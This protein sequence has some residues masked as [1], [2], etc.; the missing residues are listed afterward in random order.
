[1]P[2]WKADDARPAT[3]GMPLQIGSLYQATLGQKQYV[4]MIA[5]SHNRDHVAVAFAHHSVVFLSKTGGEYFY[6]PQLMLNIPFSLHNLRCM[7]VD[8][9]AFALCDDSGALHTWRSVGGL[10][11]SELVCQFHRPIDALK[12]YEGGLLCTLCTG[13]RTLYRRHKIPWI[14][15]Y[16]WWPV[17]GKVWVIDQLPPVSVS[18]S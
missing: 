10:W 7:A 15:R 12:W 1:M 14:E 11:K 9:C 2:C 3:I 18:T 6:Y 16:Y 5:E 8:C 17:R 13:E 4:H